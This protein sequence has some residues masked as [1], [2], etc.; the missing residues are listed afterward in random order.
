MHLAWRGLSG[1]TGN[2]TPRLIHASGLETAL[3]ATSQAPNFVA[4]VN[5]FVAQG[6]N[7]LAVISGNAW[8]PGVLQ[9]PCSRVPGGRGRIRPGPG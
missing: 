1:A 3:L 6:A 4:R 7:T 2:C 9:A 8:V 5:R